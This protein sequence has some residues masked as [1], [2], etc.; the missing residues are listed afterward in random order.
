VGAAPP[1]RLRLPQ[2][3]SL[4]LRSGTGGAEFESGGS[5][6][7]GG[8]TD[9]H[10]R[11]GNEFSAAELH[12]KGMPALQ[13][14]EASGFS[15]LPPGD[16]CGF[17]SLQHLSSLTLRCK[18]SP[19]EL[20][21]AA[22][23]LQ[24]APPSLRALRL[25]CPGSAAACRSLGP[26]LAALPQLTRLE[27]RDASIFSHLG[28]LRRLRELHLLHAAPAALGR[29]Q[30]AQ[31]AGLRG[32]CKLSFGQPST[33]HCGSGAGGCCGAGAGGCARGRLARESALERLQVG[34]ILIQ[35]P[36]CSKEVL[37]LA[38]CRAAWMHLRWT[39]LG[40]LRRLT[41][42]NMPVWGAR[43]ARWGPSYAWLSWASMECVHYK[44]LSASQPCDGPD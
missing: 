38:G 24:G 15:Q 27:L 10:R 14:L 29:E 17:G 26:A 28:R 16:E 41:V 9:G 1:P 25:E 13:S 37:G 39:L 11:Q 23:L 21:A 35:L 12:F 36:L 30:L 42:D 22:G 19:R 31:L 43:A 40:S 33:L 4:V 34:Q 2:L 3:T 20:E 32:L 18:D 44:L 6:G 5:G 8:G 7:S